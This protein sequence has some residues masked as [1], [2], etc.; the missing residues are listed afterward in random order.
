MQH[1]FFA[2]MINKSLSRLFSKSVNEKKE[3]L[4]IFMMGVRIYTTNRIATLLANLFLK[5][6][7]LKKRN[8]LAGET[9]LKL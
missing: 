3:A 6:D 4:I 9:K 8:P 7:L 1:Y 5:N 2:G